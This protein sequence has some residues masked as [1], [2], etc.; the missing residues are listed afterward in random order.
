[1]YI[2]FKI[3]CVHLAQKSFAM[4]TYAGGGVARFKL[5]SKSSTYN[6]ISSC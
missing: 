5:G 4:A 3:V 1:V 6:S 2:Y